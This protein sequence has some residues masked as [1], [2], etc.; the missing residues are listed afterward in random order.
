MNPNKTLRTLTYSITLIT[1]GPR[2]RITM[3][4]SLDFRMQ[5]SVA[6]LRDNL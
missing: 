4:V 5:K 3:T 2:S 1:L 6:G